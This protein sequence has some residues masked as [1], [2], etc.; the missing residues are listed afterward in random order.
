MVKDMTTNFRKLDKFERHDFRRWQKK[1]HFLLTTLKVVYV[2][3]TPMPELLEDATVKAIRI[4]AKW[5]NDKYICG[6][7]SSS[8]KF[9]VSNFNNYK[10]VD[11][12]LVMEQYNELL[13]ILGQYT[14]HGL[15]ID[16]S[17]SVSSIIDKLPPSWKEFKHTLKHS[18]DDLS[19]VQLEEGKNK[20]NKQNKGKKPNFKEHGSGLGSN[21]KPKLE[22]WKCGKTGHFKRDCRSSNKKNA[23]AGGSGKGSKDHS[24]D[25][26]HV[27]YK[28]MLDMSK[29]DLI[30]VIHENPEKCTTSPYT[31]Q[32]NGVAERKNKAFK[33]MV[34]SMLS[35]SG[36]SE[37][38]WR[39]AMLTA[40]YL[41]NRVPNKRNKATPYELW[42]KKRPNLSFLRVW[43]CRAVV[44]LPDLKKKTLGEKGIDCIFVGYAE[45]SK[46]YRFYV[47]EPNDSVSINSNIES[48]DAI[49][50]ENRFSSI[51]RPK[52]IIPNV[53]ESQIDDHI[54]DVPSEIPEPRKVCKWIFKRK[55]KVDGTIDNFKA[56]LVI[57]GFR[58]KE[59]INYFDTYA[60]VA[61]I[62]TI[63]LLLALAAIH[64]L[65]L[66][67]MDVKI[68]FLNG[69]LDEEVYMKQP[70]G[71]VM[72]DNEHKV[73][74]GEAD[75]I[76]G[77]KIK[78][79]NKRIV[80]TQSHYIE[81]ILK[82]F[83]REDCSP[84]STHMDPV[85]KLKPNIEK[86]VDQLDYSRAIGCLMYAMTSIRSDIAYVV[87][88]LSRF[89][90]NPSRQHWK[91]I[92]RG[93]A[94][95][96]ASKKQTCITGSTIESEFVA[97][98]AAGK[99][100]VWLRNLIHEIPI[101]PKPITPISIR[102]DSAPTMARA[103]SQIC[104]GKSRHLDKTSLGYDSQLDEKD[105]NNKSDVFES[106]S[107]SSVNESKEDNNQANDRYKACGGYHAIP[108]FYTG[109]FMPPR[110]DLSFAGLD[111]FVFKSA[112]SETIT[113]VHETETSASK[114]SKKCMEKPK[115]VRPSAPI[116]EDWESDSDDD[117]EI[118]PSIE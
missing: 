106:A 66:H 54:D 14:Q 115:S 75:V 24:Q 41:F 26:G 35:Y 93:C 60:P 87:G 83:N 78:R 84:M 30:Y 79:K 95:S 96:W 85:E 29:D 38:F 23:N 107:D 91:A 13:R 112:I 99:E 63:R 110:P 89:T 80:I 81:K 52:D 7:D 82:K 55:I 65:V 86:P 98:T 53:Q 11:S 47:I 3:T 31:P 117:Y 73:Y 36:L 100:A 42:Y 33:E 22:C 5:E 15:K 21:K 92:T 37:G 57:Q 34:N 40:C 44:R 104:N 101:W 2:L 10:M 118:R 17:F 20:N 67:Q 72:S 61:C 88:R 6:E 116:I 9:L 32:Q 76:L 97:L 62:T 16:Q 8:K 68:A 105:L 113:S 50:D 27:H 46:S 45:H 103:Y 43:G 18:K 102:C 109:N 90:S 49:F 70:E 77:I 39:K 111:D 94:I 58:Q 74:M 19:L 1:M 71:F 59:G 64:N 51:P 4:R 12:R 25:Q 69:D 48:R 114:T 28:R 56:R 108:P